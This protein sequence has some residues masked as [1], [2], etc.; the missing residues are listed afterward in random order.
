MKKIAGSSSAGRNGARTGSSRA[1]KPVAPKPA[2]TGTLV[3]AKPAGRKVAVKPAARHAIA[4]RSTVAR[5]KPAVFAQASRPEVGLARAVE[6]VMPSLGAVPAPRSRIALVHSADRD[7]HFATF[8][9][10]PAEARQEAVERGL[11]ARFLR[12]ALE[13]LQVTR[14]DLLEGLGIA[15]S[16]AARV[17]KQER[18]FPAADSERLGMLARLWS[19]VLMV[20][21]D[22][23][24]ARAWIT[25][26][27]PS[28]GGVPLQLLRTHEGFERARRSILQLA[29][30][31]YA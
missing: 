2:P 6:A 28:T 17:V 27:I 14:A 22:P 7:V 11:P 26:P 23:V 20:Y 13:C 18:P 16:S 1:G 15:S 3:L 25:S 9:R 29:Y 8:G 5:P 19:D 24:G 12:E 10:L 30:G 4:K 31:V 21:E